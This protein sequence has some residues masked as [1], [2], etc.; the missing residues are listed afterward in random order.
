[1]SETERLLHL[2][3]EYIEKAKGAC[4]AHS[5]KTK[6][7]IALRKLIAELAQAREMA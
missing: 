2:L 4:F 3:D 1:M 5:L 7:L 6:D